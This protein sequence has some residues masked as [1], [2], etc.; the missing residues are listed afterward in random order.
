MKTINTT[1]FRGNIKKYFDIAQ[2]EKV[3]IHRSKGSSFALVPLEKINEGDLF[4][5]K[6]EKRLIQSRKEKEE[7]NLTEIDTN[8]IWKSIGLE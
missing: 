3:V 1:E 8:N 7:S 6:L 4:Y 5:P 2:K